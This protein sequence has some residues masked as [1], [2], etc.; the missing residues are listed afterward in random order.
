MQIAAL[1]F[2][3]IPILRADS[4]KPLWRLYLRNSD[5]LNL[6]PMRHVCV[7]LLLQRIPPREASNGYDQPCVTEGRI[8]GSHVAIRVPRNASTQARKPALSAA[9]T[10]PASTSGL[11]LIALP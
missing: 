2:E 6:R 9:T 8:V 5:D 1:A 4:R 11:N 10:K 3:A 7:A